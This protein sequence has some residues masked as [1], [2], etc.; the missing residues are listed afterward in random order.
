MTIEASGLSEFTL[1][2][3]KEAISKRLLSDGE[4]HTQSWVMLQ[5]LA[6]NL[7][8][9]GGDRQLVDGV[10]WALAG[11]TTSGYRGVSDSL[12]FRV[13]APPSL[14][15]IHGP[16][17]S[18]KS[19][20]CEA[21]RMALVGVSGSKHISA[22]RRPNSLWISND[23]R[24]NSAG[25]AS[26]TV[27]LYDYANPAIE[28]TIN[29]TYD[30]S[31]VTREAVRRLEGVVVA[32]YG[33]DD[34]VWISWSS[35]VRAFPPVFAYSEM[36][37]EIKS[38][39]DL[40]S[41][42]TACL[43]MDTATV[44]FTG[45]VESRDSEAQAAATRLNR[46]REDALSALR[47]ADENA[48]S[49]GVTPVSKLEV[50]ESFD[51]QILG[52]WLTAN[53][54]VERQRNKQ[55]VASST[56]S[57]LAAYL[58]KFTELQGAWRAF[59]TGNLTAEVADSLGA[60]DRR[61]T[62]TGQGDN[63]STCPV[64]GHSPVDWRGEL[65]THV[66]AHTAAKEAADALTRHVKTREAKVLGPL[67]VCERALEDAADY[68]VELNAVKSVLAAVEATLVDNDDLSA[69]SLGA[70]NAVVEWWATKTARAF[71]AA[72]VASADR[73]HQ[74]MCA[75][76]EA[77]EPYLGVFEQERSLASSAAAWK[78]ARARWTSLLLELRRERSGKLAEMVDAPVSAM[79]ADAG[80][81]IRTM[82]VKKNEAELTL[83]DGK[84]NDVELAHLSAGQRNALILG[85]I[86]ARAGEGPFRFCF[87]DDPVHAFDDFRVDR[88]A[89]VVNNL[90]SEQ[91]LI[92]TTHDGRL[93]EH[94]RVYAPTDFSVLAVDRTKEG[95]VA[96]EETESPSAV[97]IAAAR[98][99]LKRFENSLASEG[100]ANIAAM[101]RMA[102]DEEI[103][104]AARRAISILPT[105][106]RAESLKPFESALTTNARVQC[107][108]SICAPSLDAAHIEAASEVLG[109]YLGT[110]QACT[111]N[112]SK[113]PPVE[114]LAEHLDA[115]VAACGHLMKVGYRD[116]PG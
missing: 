55:E 96:L 40:Q 49:A 116:V 111:H 57:D 80:I 97:L 66:T 2:D 62:A 77:I 47:T 38:A 11:I 43:A 82:D 69:A 33:N 109:A 18:G 50:P 59:S 14:T 26:V 64:C 48:E 28:L 12:T 72:A 58:D 98:A 54:L 73:R 21:L 100:A 86:L 45:H 10:Q 114:K 91:S 20:V 13:S 75:R 34:P 89:E 8:K 103:E 102:F 68:A 63:N 83:K 7:T 79:L 101:C 92:V 105:A 41:W 19:S 93:V 6:E 94:L 15:V 46:A 36:A 25:T 88:L 99:L 76:W 84:G 65:H 24:S 112:P 27:E 113:A 3:L 29:A 32:T 17:G 22:D 106:E 4:K 5:S 108:R 37:D 115:A 61:V 23:D 78:L 35:A 71:V 39:K 53:D 107:L 30:G 74:W 60:L 95:T 56:E 9:A 110:W 16:N 85:P 70:L 42:L 81:A 52:A 51:A 44:E 87:I 104:L 31:L 90:T 67:R 1:D